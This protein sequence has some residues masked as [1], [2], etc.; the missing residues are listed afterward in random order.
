MNL[1]KETCL[2]HQTIGRRIDD[3]GDHIE[4]TLKDKLSACVLY[5][6]ALDES[7]NQSD[8]A[9]LFSLEELM[10]ISILLKKC[11]TCHINGTTTGKDI[12][13]FVNL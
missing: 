13:E 11:W 2:S 8:T 4:G 3:L 7:T 12:F 1:V 6:L 10:K 9:Q 5:S